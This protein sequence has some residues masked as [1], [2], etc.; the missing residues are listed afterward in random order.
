RAL[1][2]VP[3]G[4]DSEIYHPFY[5]LGI[6]W[7]LVYEVFLSM[8]IVPLAALGR[9]W[10]LY[11]G[12]AGWLAAC[13]VHEAVAPGPLHVFPK[14]AELPLSAINTPFL[15]GVL[16]YF[17]HEHWGRFKVW[18]LLAGVVALTGGT[19]LYP[20]VAG[21]SYILESAGIAV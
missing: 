19:L 2:L 15:F 4:K 14:P 5:T 17:T 6:E 13:L 9:K 7:T 11:V 12:A 3:G 21:W 16:A 1:F 18:I 20:A 10:G 8:M